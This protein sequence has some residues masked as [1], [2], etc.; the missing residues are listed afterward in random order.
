[1][2]ATSSLITVTGR[3]TKYG[4]RGTKYDSGWEA[5]SMMT[6]NDAVAM[7]LF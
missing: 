2:A 5:S 6:R 7:Q 1:M 3:G 4:K